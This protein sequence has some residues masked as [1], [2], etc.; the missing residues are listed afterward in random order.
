MAADFAARCCTSTTKDFS[1]VLGR[2]EHEGV[3]FL[4]ITLPAFGK[5]FEKALDQGHVDRSLFAGFQRKGELPRFLGGFLDL[6]FDRSTGVLLTCPDIDAILA[7]RQLTLMFGKILLECSD[8]RLRGAMKGYIECESDIR[9]SD[10]TRA[11]STVDDFRRVSSLL[12]A[13]AFTEVDRKVYYHDTTPKHGPGATADRLRGNGKYRQRQ[14]TSRLEKVFPS[15]EYLLPNWS[16]YNQ[17]EDVEYLEPEAEIPVR[18]VSVPKTLKAPRIIGIEPTAMQYMQQALLPEFLVALSESHRRV[19]DRLGLEGFLGFDDQT[20]NQRMACEGSLTGELATLDLSEASD[21]VSN[22]LVREM[23][24]NHRHL[25]DAVDACRS[26]KA[27]VPGFGVQRLAKF[28]S[29]GSALTFPVEAMVFLAVVMI[30]IE[31]SLGHQLTVKDVKRLRRQVR[32]YGDDIIVPVV[33]VPS[34]IASLELFGA[35]VNRAKSFWSGKFRES[36]GKEYYNGEDI[37]IVRVRRVLP[38]S[39]QDAQEVISTVSLRNQLYWAGCWNSV[40]WLDNLLEGVIR[41]FPMVE[42]SSPILGRESVLG[43]ETQRTHGTLHSP[44]VKGFRVSARIP[45]NTLDDTGALLKFFLKRGQLPSADK[46]HLERS[47]RPLAV[48]IKLGWG[49]PF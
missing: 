38:T 44:L 21:R 30:G 15:G 12:Y 40:R 7:V 11:S 25:H 3:S 46:L 49:S 6:V 29:M 36:C 27:D 23:F 41:H 26:R 18:V 2:Y 8:A 10:S 43:Y 16:Y 39:R 35:K 32:I 24:R 48:D 13:S 34:V 47:G 4:T 31:K 45:S 1:T 22:Q 17:L 20:P 5:A 28:A 42:K 33:H 37:S 9:I 19:N 14:W